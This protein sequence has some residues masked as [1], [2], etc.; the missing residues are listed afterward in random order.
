MSPERPAFLL[1][2]QPYGKTI[3]VAP[4]QTLL[5]ALLANGIPWRYGCKHGMCGTCKAR[6]VSGS[7]DAGLFSTFALMDDERA[8]G[9]ILLC[10]A[11]PRSDLVIEE[12][13][14]W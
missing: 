12:V 13:D 2:C 10:C 14:L 8:E 9:I 6:L 3:A 7:I 5:D 1:T 4:E 11:K